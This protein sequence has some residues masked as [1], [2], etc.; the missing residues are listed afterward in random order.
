MIAAESYFRGI[1]FSISRWFDHYIGFDTGS[2]FPE[3]VIASNGK[4]V[5]NLLIGLTG[6]QVTGLSV[7]SIGLLYFRTAFN[8]FF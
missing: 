5:I 3:S 6:R 2:D 4:A 7:S 8:E 1:G